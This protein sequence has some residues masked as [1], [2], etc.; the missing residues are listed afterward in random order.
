[1][2]DHTFYKQVQ[3]SRSDI[4]PHIKW[5]VSLVILHMITLIFLRALCGYICNSEVLE[6]KRE[7]RHAERK[8]KSAEKRK[9]KNK[10]MLRDRF[11]EA[12]N[13]YSYIIKVT[14]T[15]YYKAQVEERGDDQKKLF[16]VVNQLLY[17]KQATELPSY[18]SALQLA[19]LFSTYFINKINKI[20]TEIE[21]NSHNVATETLR[22]PSCG[23]L[24]AFALATLEEIHTSIKS[25]KTQPVNLT[26][27]QPIC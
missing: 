1:M 18:T 7:K 12:R 11:K 15:D 23:T 16:R 4:R 5:A 6:A 19:E 25:A 27:S 20:R 24:S 22:H 9:D 26:L 13:R 21:K 14:K 17:Q 10:E 3:I 2:Y 8:W